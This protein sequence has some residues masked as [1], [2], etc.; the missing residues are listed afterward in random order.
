MTAEECKAVPPNGPNHATVHWPLRSSWSLSLSPPWQPLAELPCL[1]GV[2]SCSVPPQET[3]A[4]AIR[5]RQADG[6]KGVGDISV[7]KDSKA[8]GVAFC[9]KRVSPI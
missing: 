8:M 7:V 4:L 3:C 9:C 5:T 1:A 2:T 6:E